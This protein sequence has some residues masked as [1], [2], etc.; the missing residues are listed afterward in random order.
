MVLQFV[1]P[2]MK[3]HQSTG[4]RN[5]LRLDEETAHFLDA[6]VVKTAID[7]SNQPGFQRGMVVRVGCG[8][9][10]GFAGTVPQLPEGWQLEWMSSADFVRIPIRH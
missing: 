3:Q 8:W 6:G 2:S 9:G 4:F 7:L 1:L 10:A 5:M